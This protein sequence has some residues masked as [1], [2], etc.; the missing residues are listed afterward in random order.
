VDQIGLILTGA[1]LDST[2]RT[3]V[4]NFIANNVSST[5]YY[6]QVSAAIHLI[7]TSPRG[8]TQE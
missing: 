2:T 1:P 4:L 6:G 8:A 5:D 7:G 3:T